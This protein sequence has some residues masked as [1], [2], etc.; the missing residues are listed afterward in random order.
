MAKEP[1]TG[2]RPI[3]QYAHKGKKRVNNPPVGL[4]SPELDRK[5]GGEEAGG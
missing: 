4:V 1:K 5:K 3:E 2:K